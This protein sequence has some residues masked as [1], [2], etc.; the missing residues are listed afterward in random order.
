MASIFDKFTSFFRGDGDVNN[1]IRKD[2]W[3]NIM[4]SLISYNNR[5]GLPSRLM[6]TPVLDQNTLDII[7]RS[8]G[9]GKRIIDLIANEMTRRWFDIS[10]DPDGVILSRLEEI[11]AKHKI[12]NMLKWGRL[13]GGV[14]GVLG[15][16]DGGA[17]IDPV[18]ENRIKNVDFIH[19]FDRHQVTWIQQNL[20]NNPE[21]PK[22]GEPEFY[23][24]TPYHSGKLF[25][26]HESRIIRMDA[27]DLPQRIK[28][29]NQ[30]W[31]DSVLQSAYR[32]I[33][34][35]TDIYTAANNITKDFIQT[36]LSVDNLTDLLASGQEDLIRKRLQI[37][38]E[39]RSV[40][41]TILLDSQE[42][43]QKQASSIGGME[44]LI[45][46]FGLRLA[47]VTGIP[48]T[49]LFGQSPAGLQSTGQADIRMFYDMIS[50]EQ[51]SSLQPVL[52]KI[53]K[54]LILSSELKFKEGRPDNWNIH[55]NPLW[56]P[57]EQ[58]E[59]TYRKT[60]AETDSI[61]IQ[62]GVLDPSEVAISRFGGE[63]YSADTK[64]DLN[65]R[66]EQDVPEEEVQAYENEQQEQPQ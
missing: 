57:T 49:F 29:I 6:D 7:Y 56:Q 44:S 61:Y 64:I 23:T 52:E 62:T 51:E 27:E 33:Q 37:L 25:T 65:A 38:D 30:D 16:R 18:R 13:Y 15:V 24:I 58:E 41:N 19:I 21:H 3:A 53:V 34:D 42:S 20:Y 17:L 48:Y 40:A 47:A 12:N 14:V 36:I 32:E 2:G 60:V 28:Y 9:I 11:G 66:R 4:P 10:G 35:L 54:Y 46:R 50:S 26:V 22:Y 43:Y 63:A 39:S 8:N 5:S 45:D 31:G 55:F 59:A 1:K